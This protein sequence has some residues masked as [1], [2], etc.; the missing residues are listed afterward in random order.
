MNGGRPA[1]GTAY[2]SSKAGLMELTRLAVEEL[3][4]IHSTVMVF[5]AGPGLVRTAMTEYQATSEG[6]QCWIPG[7]RDALEAGTARQPE[8]IAQ[9]TIELVQNAIPAWSGKYYDPDT[10]IS[11]F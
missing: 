3:K 11:T 6:G 4:R 1:G 2:A 10:D 5:G 9:K 7:V 8:E